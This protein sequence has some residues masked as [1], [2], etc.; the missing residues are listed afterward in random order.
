[1]PAIPVASSMD[2]IALMTVR[3]CRVAAR[4]GRQAWRHYC[5]LR[6]NADAPHLMSPAI[7][8]FNGYIG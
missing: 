6:Y 3:R 7:V 4:C 5:D 1:M 8:E 2:L